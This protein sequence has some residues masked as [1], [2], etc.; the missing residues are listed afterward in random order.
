MTKQFCDDPQ[1]QINKSSDVKLHLNPHFRSRVD[2]K[3]GFK[4]SLSLSLSLFRKLQNT[5]EETTPQHCYVS[6]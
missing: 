2:L 5:G 1:T 4:R 6:I 3:W